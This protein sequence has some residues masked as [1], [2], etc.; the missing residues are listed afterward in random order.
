M[1]TTQWL[2]DKGSQPTSLSF[3]E[4][5]LHSSLGYRTPAQVENE[6]FR[7]QDLHL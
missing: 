5:L 4:S 3:Y 1:T 7:R 2:Y 6:Y